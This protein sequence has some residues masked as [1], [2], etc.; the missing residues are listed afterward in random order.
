MVEDFVNLGASINFNVVVIYEVVRVFIFFIYR[1]V[2]GILCTRIY[3]S[4][5]QGRRE[6][7]SE[8]LVLSL[9]IPPRVDL[10]LILYVAIRFVII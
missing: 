7:T 10:L 4:I 9:F 3:A 1:V 2:D 5:A 6:L 8:D